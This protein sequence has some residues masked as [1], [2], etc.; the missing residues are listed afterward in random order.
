MPPLPTLV[1]KGCG[2]VNEG[3]RVYC[4]SC[5][6]KLDREILIA[7]QQQ[8]AVS[9]ERQQRE[10]KKMMT[11]GD[12]LLKRGLQGLGKT[13][14]LAALSAVLI[15]A[16]L[17]PEGMA[18]EVKKEAALEAPQ[19]DIH[20]ERLLA[21]PAGQRIMIE[22][23]QVN[24][25]LRRE[26][27]K[28]IPAGLGHVVSLRR[29]FVNFEKD[30]VRF[31]IQADVGGFYPI[32][33]TLTGQLRAEKAGIIGVCTASSIGRLPLPSL[34]FPYIEPAV[35]MLLD[36]FQHERQLLNKVG[37]LELEKGQLILGSRGPEPTPAPKIL[38]TRRL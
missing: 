24:A 12:G 26:R 23:E 25:Y 1:C 19:L 21:A 8:Q 33:A 36:S 14:A 5:G 17:P 28:K 9:P 10:I 20:L 31:N 30:S 35:P 32:Y 15:V 11:P 37:T 2:H 27:F 29:I 13:L 3:E 7:Q 4:H 16:A 6:I 34:L 18:P 22:E 38:P